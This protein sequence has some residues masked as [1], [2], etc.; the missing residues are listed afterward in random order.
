M[1]GG[2]FQYEPA[3][4]AQLRLV[5]L[6]P[7]HN[8]D[9]PIECELFS[10]QLDNAPPYEALSYFWGSPNTARGILYIVLYDYLCLRYY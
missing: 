10:Y 8:I 7:G 3:D 6:R 5:H 1:A 2:I 9:K 4:E